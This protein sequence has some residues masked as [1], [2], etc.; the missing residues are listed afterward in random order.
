MPTCL[1]LYY[2]VPCVCTGHIVIFVSQRKK[3]KRCEFYSYQQRSNI[4]YSVCSEQIT[5]CGIPHTYR[6]VSRSTAL[7]GSCPRRNHRCTAIRRRSV[8]LGAR[9]RR[10]CTLIRSS[11]RIPAARPSLRLHSDVAC[12]V[13]AHS[14]SRK[15][16]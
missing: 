15:V 12:R 11:D 8:I 6:R 5:Q 3:K 4:M 2:N 16:E 1:R 9:I 7:S 13:C 10:F 14:L